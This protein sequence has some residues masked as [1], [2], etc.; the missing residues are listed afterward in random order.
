MDEIVDQKFDHWEIPREKVK[1][2]TTVLGSGAFGVVLLGTMS[3]PEESVLGTKV[4]VKTIKS[5]ILHNL[6]L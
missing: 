3:E 1:L 2:S 4:A 5:G 6:T